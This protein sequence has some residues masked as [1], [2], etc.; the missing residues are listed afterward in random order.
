M[1]VYRLAPSSGS[2]ARAGPDDITAQINT[3]HWHIV[4]SQSFPLVIPGFTDI[5]ENGAYSAASVY[6]PEDVAGIVTYAGT[7]RTPALC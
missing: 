5:A 7:V 3:F 4:D 1:W 2:G 6:S